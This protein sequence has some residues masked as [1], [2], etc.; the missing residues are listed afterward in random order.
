MSP[1]LR[2]RALNQFGTSLGSIIN[3]WTYGY[4]DVATKIIG[5][6][7]V[8][9]GAEYTQL[10][11]LGD[12]IGRPTYGFYNIWDFAND[13]PYQE[14][15]AY[16]SVTGLPG[17]NRSDE[18]ENLFGGFVQDSWKVRPN[19][20]LNYGLRYSYFGSLTSKQNN[21][22]RVTFGSG[23]TQYTGLTVQ[24]NSNLWNPQKGNFG[25]EFGFNWSPNAVH[26]NLVV[27]GGYG[28]NFNQEEIAITANTAY[29]PPTQ[30]QLNYSFTSPSN[31]GVNGANIIYGISSSPTSLNGFAANPNAITS[32]NA[33]GLPT[34]GNAGVIIIGN[35]YGKLPTS[36]TEHYSLDT[37]YQL[38]KIMVASLG[39]QGSVGRHLI[40]HENP[41]APGAVSGVA[42]NPL[43]TGGDFWI[44]EGSSNNNAFLAEAKHNS[45]QLSIDAQ[46]MWA[47]S[48]DTDGSGPYSEDPYFPANAAYSYGRS[49]FNVGKSVQA[50]RPLPARLLPG[51]AWLG[52]E[53]RRRLVA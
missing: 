47:K 20:T 43:V 37:E 32:Y 25:P 15:G 19:L 30:N 31:P 42:L 1:S 22:P 49:D 21:L 5:Q 52:G 27:R 40:N 39:Y 4:K 16:N 10:R 6:H 46:F 35:G 33:N 36:Y 2:L 12:P 50:L 17:G 44:N 23:S 7:S 24:S 28:L 9:F 13:A 34:A 18:R 51:L 29:N 11:Y 41:N 14:S 38:G 53:D 8:K 45:R 48:M 26:S 3:Q